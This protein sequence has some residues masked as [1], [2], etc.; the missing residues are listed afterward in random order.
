MD[1]AEIAARLQTGL[2]EK[3]IDDS[4][5]FD[6]GEAGVISIVD[7]K[8]ELA[9]KDTDCTIRISPNNLDKL[10]SGQL[11]PMTGFAM[12]KIKVSGD[13]TVAMKLSQML[14]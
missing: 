8:A 7:S 5:K 13:M 9:D 6:C 4:L 11:N 12:G 2:D 1:L 3:P 14:G 10:L